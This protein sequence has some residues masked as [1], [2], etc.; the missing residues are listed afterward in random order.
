MQE[1]ATP[2]EAILLELLDEIRKAR[3]LVDVNTAAGI[4]WQD[5]S[6]IAE[7]E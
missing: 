2:L 7:P 1:Q 5:L 6:G 4:A 3:S